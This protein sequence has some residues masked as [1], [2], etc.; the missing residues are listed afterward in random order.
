[1]PVVP[2]TARGHV[3]HAAADAPD[4]GVP[5]IAIVRPDSGPARIVEEGVGHDD[6][7]LGEALPR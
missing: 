5:A 6:A 7:G 4:V 1:M 3:Q 2:A